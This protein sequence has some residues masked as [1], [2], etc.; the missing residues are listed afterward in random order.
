MNLFFGLEF[1]CTINKDFL[2]DNDIK[3]PDYGSI[4]PQ[5][6]FWNITVD[7]S[8]RSH[9]SKNQ[10]P[11]K[12]VS[13]EFRYKD[14]QNVIYDL[15]KNILNEGNEFNKIQV[16]NSCGLHI[17]FSIENEH[18]YLYNPS[19]LKFL[20]LL[21]FAKI[22]KYQPEI[23]PLFYRQYYRAHAKKFIGLKPYKLVH[24]KH[25]EFNFTTEHGI[26]WR[27]FN[28]QGITDWQTIENI[29]CIALAQIKYWSNKYIYK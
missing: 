27:S 18:P 12:F 1:E 10:I 13:N 5:S 11:I 28:I 23:F 6:Y 22:K 7:N 14:I 8:I 24:D 29:I 16:N 20:K 3:M 21:T 9:T 15:Q 25:Y 2:I 19:T 17:H 4:V 26:E